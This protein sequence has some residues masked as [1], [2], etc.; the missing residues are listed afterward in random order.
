MILIPVSDGSR[1]AP[2]DLANERA[3]TQ[4]L[5]WSGVLRWSDCD[6][7]AVPSRRR[8]GLSWPRVC[9]RLLPALRRALVACFRL[10]A[11]VTDGCS[12]L[13]LRTTC[14]RPDTGSTDD[15][16]AMAKGAVSPALDETPACRPKQRR[17]QR[18]RWLPL[19]K[20]KQSPQPWHGCWPAPRYRVRHAGGSAQGGVVPTEIACGVVAGPLFVSIFTAIGAR[21]VGYDWR[22]HAVSSL[23]VGR[24]G[25]LQRANFMLTGALYCIAAQGLARSPRRTVGPRVV[26]ALIFG[27]GAGLVGSGLFVTDPVGG[28]R[29]SSRDHDGAHGAPVVAP[30]AAECC[31]T[32]SP[33]RSSREY[34]L[35]P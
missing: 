5:I 9:R 11:V 4:G 31:T 26:P 18:R 1:S 8:F 10:Q 7:Q 12:A 22:R 15:C 19:V 24:G 13:V 20:G 35:R 2:T 33:Y 28:F 27:V 21:R 14:S 3:P 30:L 25:W 6:A 23:A 17:H 34:L 29:P 32:S 16:F